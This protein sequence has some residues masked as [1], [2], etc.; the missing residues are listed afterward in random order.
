MPYVSDT[1]TLV[2]RKFGQN[3]SRLV[4]RDRTGR[5]LG[6]LG[7]PGDYEGVHLSPD[8]RFAAITKLEP[9]SGHTKI[10]IDSLPDGLLEPLSDSNHAVN[11]MWSEDSR[12][13]YY[14]DDRRGLLLRRSM[15]PRGTEEVVMEMGVDRRTHVGDISP[16]G[17]YAVAEL[18]ANYAHAEAVWTEMKGVS[19]GGP[20]GHS[21]DAPGSE[22]MLPSFLRTGGG[23]HSLRIRREGRRFM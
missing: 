22:G 8:D 19:K 5:E 6:V 4:W 15:S 20:Q 23:W 14:N 11:P 12:A 17:R 7:T 3:T 10:W 13:V 1:G 18:I 2:I 21:I 16:D 9:V